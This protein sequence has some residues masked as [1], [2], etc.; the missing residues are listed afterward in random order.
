MTVSEPRTYPHGVTC[1]I[2]V[3]APDVDAA[4]AFYGGLLGW[5]FADAMPPDAPTRYVIAQ[6]G[7]R[8]AAAIA[9][10]APGETASW[11]T[12]VAVDDCDAA[13]DHLVGLAATVVD[14][15]ADAGPGGR[16][17]TLRDPEGAE[18]RLWQAR[19][20]LGAQVL[21][22][23]GACNFSNLRALDP[24]AAGAWYAD[25]FGWRVV[26][27]GWS[28]AV[29]VPGYGDH[30]ASTVDPD[31]RTRQAKAPE[32]FADVIGGIVAADTGA[33]EAPHWHVVLTVA[34]RDRAVTD[35]ERLGGTVHETHEDEWTRAAVVSDPAGA[36]FTVSQFAPQDW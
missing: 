33:G 9:S 10:A 27:Q 36:R 35:V 5:T 20:R 29:Q 31:I 6:L 26:D 15:P 28:R 11:R 12:Y 17:S 7:G 8:D 25:A 21:N 32:G 1:W 24:G 2:D 30:L 16:T 19:A 23:P 18:V 4:A 22:E 3:A 14:P 13:T 34:D